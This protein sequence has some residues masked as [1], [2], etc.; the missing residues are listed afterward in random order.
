MNTFVQ[1]RWGDVIALFLIAFGALLIYFQ[2]SATMLNTGTGL[3]GAGLV[4]IRV[5]RQSE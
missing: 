3:V 5:R 2:N 1:E 4:M